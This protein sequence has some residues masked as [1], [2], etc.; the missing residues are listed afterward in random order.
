MANIKI[1]YGTG[2]GNTK[3][4]CETVRDFLEEK[5]HEVTL[6]MAK[7]T[8]PADVGDYDVLILASPTYGQGLLEA[9]FAKFMMKL[10]AVDL[11]DKVCTGI[12]LGDP[13]YYDD[14][15]IESANIIF[16]FLKRKEAKVAVMPLRISKS[17]YPQLNEYVKNWTD[18]LHAKING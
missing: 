5:G 14:Y 12:G 18:N 17:P 16:K 11:K 1:V 3:V 9:Y 7:V 2:G 15:H 10:E 8:E 6:L 13:K 4:V